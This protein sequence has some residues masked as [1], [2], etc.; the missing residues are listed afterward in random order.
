MEKERKE[1][2]LLMNNQKASVVAG[3]KF[4]CILL[5]S[6]FILSSLWEGIIG[7]IDQCWSLK[8]IMMVIHTFKHR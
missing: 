5:R 8:E 2:K 1:K 3:T 7:F 4:I 6:N